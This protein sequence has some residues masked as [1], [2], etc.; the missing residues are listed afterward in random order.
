MLSPP[1]GGNAELVAQAPA[2]EAASLTAGYCRDKERVDVLRDV[3]LRVG[4]GECL[5]V[6]GPSGC[7]KSTLLHVLA[8]LLP[9]LAGTVTVGGTLVAESGR[10]RVSSHAAYLFQRDLLLPWKTAL[11][12]AAF[13]ALQAR[14]RLGSRT[15]IEARAEELLDEFG[16]ADSLSCLPHQLSGGMR[17]RV[18]LARTLV[19]DRGLVLLDEPFSSLDALTRADLHDWLLEVMSR[20]PA[21]WV[22]VTHDVQEAVLLADRVAVLAGRPARIDGVVTVPVSRQRR[23]ERRRDE[24]AEGLL[25]RTVTEV[26]RALLQGREA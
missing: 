13:A 17:Q 4:A 21:T 5:A 24:L 15:E 22:M 11:G 26:E 20:H 25:R 19:L 3:D 8:G 6:V 9:P 1:H 7:G 14:P 10:A 16:L 23:I 12:N 2:V 18:A